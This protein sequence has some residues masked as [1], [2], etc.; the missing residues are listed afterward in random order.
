MQR[1]IITGSNG[2][3]G[4][5]LRNLMLE[6]GHRVYGATRSN[7]ELVDKHAVEE[8]IKN[9]RPTHIYNFAGV[10]DVLDPYRSW[11]EMYKQNC[12][13]PINFLSSILGTDIRFFQA[14]S[15]F[16]YEGGED[17]LVKESSGAFPILPYGITK[18]FSH[19]LIN[20][21]RNLGVFCCSGVL[22]NHDSE[23]RGGK[24]L[25]Q[26]VILGIKEIL[27]GRRGEL[28]LK[29]IDAYKDMSY[30]GDVVAG[31][32]KILEHSEPGDY[33][34][35]S[36]RLTGIR[37]FVSRAFRFVNLDYLDYVPENIGES[38]I[39]VRCDST[40]MLETFGWSAETSIDDMIKIMI[41]DKIR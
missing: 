4:T 1:I 41:E 15:S 12:L 32:V 38:K 11:D 39:Y 36:G 3:D 18:L 24:F 21:Y 28:V 33:M 13:I 6:R 23:F 37:D 25:T 14:S 34:V 22:F 17:R 27:E 9:F 30:A 16:M 29:N 20:E 2:Q 31:C 35:G 10:S 5:I 40:K 26:K 19:N 8:L 7:T